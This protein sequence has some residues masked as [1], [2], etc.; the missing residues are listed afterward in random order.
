MV[1][2][3]LIYCRGD[4]ERFKTYCFHP[5]VVMTEET[6]KKTPGTVMVV[7]MKIKTLTI[8]T[9]HYECKNMELLIKIRV[10]E[11]YSLGLISLAWTIVF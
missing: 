11:E 3:I 10:Q 1:A 2:S 6:K 8:P 4:V 5:L 9:R 7:Q